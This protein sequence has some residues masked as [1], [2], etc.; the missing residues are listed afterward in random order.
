M[1][2]VKDE[3]CC[4]IFNWGVIFIESISREALIEKVLFLGK[5]ILK[6]CGKLFPLNIMSV[7]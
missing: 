1:W 5:S 6:K 4:G 3:I 7:M 2:V